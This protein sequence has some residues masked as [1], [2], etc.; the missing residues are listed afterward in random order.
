MTYKEQLEEQIQKLKKELEQQYFYERVY[1]TADRAREL[2]DK[3][4]AEHIEFVK[5]HTMKLIKESVEEGLKQVKIP[6]QLPFEVQEWLT[7]LGYTVGL[8]LY[9][10]YWK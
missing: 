1:I 4:L 5:K 6:Y 3:A 7:K 9:T 10:I 2:T 8:D